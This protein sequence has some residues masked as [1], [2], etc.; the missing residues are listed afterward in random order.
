M[1]TLPRHIAAA[2]DVAPDADAVIAAHVVDTAAALAERCGASLTLL[3]ACPPP[4][5]LVPP[6]LD[7]WNVA[8]ASLAELV[9]AQAEHAKG[10]LAK[11]EARVKQR[12]VTVDSVA[13]TDPGPLPALLAQTAK[14]QGCDLIIICTRGKRGLGRVLLGSVAERTAHLAEVP[15][16]LLQ[17]PSH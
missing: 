5:N 1:T 6:P 8:A 3:H 16:M 13:I 4:P 2:I 9:K 12:G 15:I 10:E 11:L 7:V 14:D 17:P